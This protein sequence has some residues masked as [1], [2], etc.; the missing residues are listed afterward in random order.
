MNT[1][2]KQ[3]FKKEERI[4]ERKLLDQLFKNGKSF[5]VYPFKVYYF[6]LE[7]TGCYPARVLIS[8]PKRNFKRAVDRN[9]IKRLIREA[10]R[11]NKWILCPSGNKNDCRRQYLIGLIYTAKTHMDYV[12]VERKIILILQQ[13]QKRNEQVT[14]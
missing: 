9:R 7:K 6:S 1:P 5:F 2:L 3:T 10:Y 4:Y 14:R 12:E 11:R 13:L 8:V